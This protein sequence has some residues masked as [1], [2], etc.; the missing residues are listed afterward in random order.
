MV[1][2]AVADDYVKFLF[3]FVQEFV[4]VAGDETD[5]AFEASFL[6]AVYVSLRKICTEVI[7]LRQISEDTSKIGR[8]S[9][10]ERVASP[11]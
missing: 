1:E 8:A 11:V 9:C 2:E 3:G 4:D 7:A 5:L 6:S 10:R